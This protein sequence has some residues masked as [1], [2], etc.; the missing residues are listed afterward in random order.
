MTKK[1]RLFTEEQERFIRANA[2]GITT[3]ALT[4]MLNIHFGTSF[5][6]RQV[7]FYKYRRGILS[8]YSSFASFVEN[9]KAH[10]YKPGHDPGLHCFQKGKHYGPDTEFKKGHAPNNVLPIGSVVM[11]ADGYLWVK[12]RERGLPGRPWRRWEQKH[13]LL[14]EAANGPIPSGKRLMFKDGDHLNVNLDN[15]ALVTPGEMAVLNKRRMM[16]SDPEITATGL[17]IV[18][19]LIKAGELRRKEIRK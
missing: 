12:V 16:S 14:W 8:G 1:S 11:G 6:D 18:K 2:K 17:M 10:R 15:L 4:E 13:R 19:I 3:M 7:G 5:R 9:G